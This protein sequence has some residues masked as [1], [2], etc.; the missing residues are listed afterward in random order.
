MIILKQLKAAEAKS[1]RFDREVETG[2][3]Q[4]DTPFNPFEATQVSSVLEPDI[5]ILLR[6]IT[7]GLI[8]TFQRQ[9][10]VKNIELHK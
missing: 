8:L 5:K 1:D 9:Q 2:V 6:I 3:E 7:L 10:L 4:L